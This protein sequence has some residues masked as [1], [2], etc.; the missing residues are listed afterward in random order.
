MRTASVCLALW[1][2]G[3]G[4]GGGESA[5]AEPAGEAPAAE[6]PAPK[7]EFNAQTAYDTV[8]ATCHGAKGDGKGPAGVALNPRPASFIDP[9]FWS[10]KDRDHIINVTKNGGAAV[11]KSAL[12]VPYGATYD[13]A[14]IGQ[15]A[16]V[17]MK[18]KPAGEAAA[19]GPDKAPAAAPPAA[20]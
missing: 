1:A 19:P 10:D 8:C 14:Q 20:Q 18:F 6:A 9:A 3:C 15:I 2:L 7:A 4:G 11:G 12:M 13:D 17:V 5:S 16:D